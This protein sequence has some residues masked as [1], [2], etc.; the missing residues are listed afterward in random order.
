MLILHES[1][2]FPSRSSS[3]K[4]SNLASLL[5]SLANLASWVDQKILYSCQPQKRYEVS[6][7]TLPSNIKFLYTINYNIGLIQ[8]QYFVNYVVSMHKSYYFYMTIIVVST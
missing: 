6:T 4:V 5:L 3:T 1:I 8:N 7:T 2:S